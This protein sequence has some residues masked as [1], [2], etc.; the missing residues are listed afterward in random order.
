[1]KIKNKQKGFTLLEL[2]LVIATIG[3]LAA[4]VL[5][6]INPN[7]QISQARNA[8]KRAEINSIYKALEQYIIDVGS[9]PPGITTTLQDIC[10][11]GL[12]QV[13]GETNCSGKVDLRVLVPTYLS[14]IPSDPQGNNY[15]VAL[16]INNNRALVYSRGELGQTISVNNLIDVDAEAYLSLVEIADN[17][18][19]EPAVRY[20]ITK[21]VVNLKNDGMWNNL[22]A[23]NILVGAKTLNGALIPLKGPAPTNFNFIPSDYNRKTGLIGN[24]TQSKYLDSNLRASDTTTKFHMSA[25]M[26]TG[27]QSS[28]CAM[29]RTD[30]NGFHTWICGRTGGYANKA[31]P[32]SGP[33]PTNITGFIGHFRDG[34]GQ[35]I[36]KRQ[37]GVTVSNDTAASYQMDNGTF[38]VFAWDVNGTLSNFTNSRIAFYSIG[39]TVDLAKLD[40]RITALITEL[41]SIIQ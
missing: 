31:Y 25:Y 10:N 24:S 7:R 13:G 38:K 35:A 2:L 27:L 41:N 26:S 3:V 8:E 34:S 40:Q 6:A 22:Q 37:D 19:L 20:A 16:N 21:F 23:S 14:N 17:Q 1:M 12:E 36:N 4:I 5:L 9:Y 28:S 15:G 33:N 18:S 39:G 30:S 32:F 11:T 29:G